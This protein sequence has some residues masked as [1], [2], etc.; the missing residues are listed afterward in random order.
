LEEKFDS[1][2]LHHILRQENEVASTLARLGL[3]HEPTPLGVFTQNLFKPSIQLKEDIPVPAPGTSLGKDSPVPA[4]ETPPGKDGPA[5]TSEVNPG[6][7]DGP[8]KPN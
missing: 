8:I 5:P 6:A 4:L 3:S 2:E 1:L 7:P